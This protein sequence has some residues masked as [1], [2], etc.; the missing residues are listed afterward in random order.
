MVGWGASGKADWG[1]GEMVRDTRQA[2]RC[3]VFHANH[4]FGYLEILE[5]IILQGRRHFKSHSGRP[6]ALKSSFIWIALMVGGVEG[7]LRTYSHLPPKL[8]SLS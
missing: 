5:L 6:E 8:L 2:K 1:A 4:V 7:N 3:G